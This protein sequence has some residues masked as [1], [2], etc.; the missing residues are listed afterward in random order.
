[1]DKFKD[2]NSI[3]IDSRKCSKNC[4]FI[5]FENEYINNYHFIDDAIS[6][7]ATLIISNR[8]IIC[9]IKNI[10]YKNIYSIFYKLLNFFYPNNIKLIGVTGTDGKTSTCLMLKS[11][12]SQKTNCGYIGTNGIIYNNKLIKTTNTTPD[13][14]TIRKTLHDMYN[15][16]IIYVA[17]ECSSEGILSNRLFSLEFDCLIY[18]NIS[19][20]HLNTH[21]TMQNYVMTKLS[22]INKIKKNGMIFVNADDN[23]LNN[24]RNKNVITYGISNG[25]CIAYNIN[26][27]LNS[28]TFEYK[29]KTNN[30][31]TI[32][33][34]GKYNVYNFL[35]STLVLEYYNLN[36]DLDYSYMD[37]I[38][39]RFELLETTEKEI[40][41]DFA[42]T[43]NALENLLKNISEV[44]H[45]KIIL[46]LGSSGGKDKSKRPLLGSIANTYASTII[47]T[48]EDP[49]NELITNIFFDLIKR[50]KKEYYLVLFR[51]DAIKMGLELCDKN[52][53]LVIVG[54]GLENNEQIY[55]IKFPYN[56]YLYTKSLLNT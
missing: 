41:I 31:V 36:T 6:K 5:V 28:T 42:H 1:M 30:V 55:N 24:I 25:D 50:I 20:E 51:K 17:M 14:I 9:S 39:G 29:Y 40:V 13:I 18:T 43:P 23:Y 38:D 44:T 34:F 10:V 27:S 4:I 7:G 3:Q 37:K 11:L 21:K 12:I 15:S 48:S 2:Y 54:K 47:I 16:G 49:K 35:A 26:Q 33:F 46:V 56:D 19:H 32:P 52:S 8:K 22:L 53:I 45:K